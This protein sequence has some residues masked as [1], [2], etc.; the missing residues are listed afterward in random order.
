MEAYAER[1]LMGVV[2]PRQG[3]ACFLVEGDLWMDTVWRL[4][5]YLEGPE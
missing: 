5:L 1:N 2:A 4:N 3:S